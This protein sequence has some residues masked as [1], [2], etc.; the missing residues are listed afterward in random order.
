MTSD[1]P[2]IHLTGAFV[3]GALPDS[4]GVSGKILR[5]NAGEGLSVHTHPTERHN[6][7]TIVLFGSLTCHGRPAIEGQIIKAGDVL[8]WVAGEPHG[9]TALE[10]GAALLQVNKATPK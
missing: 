3:T 8:D 6:H 1:T 4:S 2:L 5:F 9:F 7:I 10:G